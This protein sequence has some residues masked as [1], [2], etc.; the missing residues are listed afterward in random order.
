MQEPHGEGRKDGVE[1]QGAGPLHDLNPSVPGLHELVSYL[2]TRNVAITL[3]I[4]R[5]SLESSVIR[6]S[7]LIDF[8]F[9]IYVRFLSPK[10]FFQFCSTKL[11][12]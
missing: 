12:E 11:N 9:L 10:P 8:R 1:S 6:L 4:R 3:R 7:D 2:R 5:K